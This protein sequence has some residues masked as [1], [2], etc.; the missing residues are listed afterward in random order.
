MAGIVYN[1]EEK[2]EI[3]ENTVDM[4]TPKSMRSHINK[5]A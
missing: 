1:E 4:H 3:P 2:L 5:V